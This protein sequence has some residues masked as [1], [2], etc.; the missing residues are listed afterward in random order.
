MSA[1]KI[2]ILKPSSLGDVVQSLPV[3]RLLKLHYPK[4]EIYWWLEA[5]LVPLLKNDPDLAGVFPFERK[6]WSS[7]LKWNELIQS[8]RQM[9]RQ[10]FDLV[11]DLQG[12]ARSGVFAWL[13]NGD[14]LVGVDDPR[15]GASG[16]YDVRVPRPSYDTHAVDWYLQ[17]LKQLQVPVNRPFEWLPVNQ[18]AKAIV[19]QQRA[20]HD[21]YILLNPGARWLN[22]RWPIEHFATLAQRLAVE[23]PGTGFVLTGSK[24]ESSLANAIEAA[25]PG[26]C[27]NVTGRTSLVEMVEWIRGCSVMVTNDTGPMHLASALGKPVLALFGPTDAS[28]TGPYGQMQNV[29]R[30]PIPCAPCMKDHC[31]NKNHLECLHSISPTIV[32]DRVRERLNH[33]ALAIPNQ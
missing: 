13:A 6:R 26:R 22:K 2:L 32:Q 21:R 11:I 14:T 4:S 16:L 3:L 1:L 27:L 9:R 20:S 28:R 33:S 18:Y 12:L 7:P 5:S 30:T 23:Y 29:L 10:K 15:E 25:V 24:S 31:S 19:D 17:V 8:I